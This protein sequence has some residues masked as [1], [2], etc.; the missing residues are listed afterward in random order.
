M[1]ETLSVAMN[2]DVIICPGPEAS[3]STFDRPFKLL[4]KDR[5]FVIDPASLSKLSPIFATMLFGKDFE[6]G[7]ELIREIVDEKSADI[8]AF[9]KCLDDSR[10][11]NG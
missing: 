4:V 11:L 9:L 1:M 10:A 2:S 3:V 6:N 7:R 5:T 8:S